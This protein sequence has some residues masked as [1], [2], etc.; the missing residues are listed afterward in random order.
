[1]TA[2]EQRPAVIDLRARR[3]YRPDVVSLACSK[4][5]ATR[6]RTRF[7][8]AEFADALEQLLGWPPTPELVEAWESTVAPPGQV[9]IACEVIASRMA[10]AEPG[11]AD[12]VGSAAREAE[13]EQS[14][15]L[16]EPGPQSIDSLREGTLEIARA[17]NRSALDLFGASHRIALTP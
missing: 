14:R 15:L 7:S 17:A 3:G 1:M 6:E 13:A 10:Q 12:E 4:V 11:D 2:R 5:A 8:V 9:V 16:T